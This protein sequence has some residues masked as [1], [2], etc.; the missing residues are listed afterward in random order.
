MKCFQHCNQCGHP[1]VEEKIFQAFFKGAVKRPM[2]LGPEHSWCPECRRKELVKR[3]SGGERAPLSAS[4]AS[5]PKPKLSGA[6]IVERRKRPGEEVIKSC[7]YFCN[8]GCDCLVY[9]KGGRVQRIE[10]DPESLTTQ[11]KLCAKGLASKQ[12][13]YH[14]DRLIKPLKRV[15]KR[16]EGKWQPISWDEALDTI[17]DNLSQIRKKYGP[18]GVALSH[19]TSRGWWEVFNR[20]AN[21]YKSQWMGPGVAQCFWP[22]TLAGQLVLGGPALECPDYAHTRCLLVWAA[23]PPATWP[24]KAMGM[25]EAKGRGAPLI[26]VDPVLSHTASK[27]DLWLKLR[28]GTDA[29]LA[30][31][32]LQVIIS[33]GLYDSEFVGRWCIGFEELAKRVEAFPPSRVEAITWVPKEQIINASRLYAAGRPAC[34][35]QCVAIEQNA[36]TLSTCRSLAILSAITGNIDVPGGNLFPMPKGVVDRLGP[37]WTKIDLWSEEEK[38]RILGYQKFPMLSGSPQFNPARPNAVATLVWEAMI[39]GKPYPIKGLYLHGSNALL[40]YAD[41]QKVR[42]ALES[43]DFFAAVDFF[44]T[45]TTDLADILLPSATWLERDFVGS[46][47]QVSPDGVHLQQKVVQIGECRS[48]VTI[49]NQLAQRLGLGHFFESEKALADYVLSPLGWTFED[50]KKQKHYYIPMEYKKFRTNGFRTPSG[51][52]ELSS[53][54][55]AKVGGDP[56]PHYVEPFESPVSTPDLAQTYP[57]I[58]TTGGRSPVYRHTELRN[59][60]WLREIDPHLQAEMNDQAGHRLGLKDGDRVVIESPRGHIR[61]W[62][63][64]HPGIDPRV[65]QVAHGWPAEEN[66][67]LL[68]DN[69]HLAELVGSTSLRGLLCRVYKDPSG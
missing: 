65:I 3:L 64:L 16:G 36:D 53:S 2:K 15:G 24:I 41:S 49:M 32:M 60:P 52:V 28:P 14:P 19:G 13:L 29:A 39:T 44:H 22:R 40:S 35:T 9:V 11:G 5:F 47:I 33:E 10:G 31:G 6:E 23:N 37:A 58:L 27:A 21:V 43:L 38:S 62:L 30:L 51:K 12:V 54:T 55:V 61:V 26:V 50:F 68:T 20:F 4:S 48:D 34:I 8:S 1:I 69:E 42:Q 18:T 57:F 17:V 46:S 56:L 25:M 63:R 7:C 66:I 59:I 45:P 67:N